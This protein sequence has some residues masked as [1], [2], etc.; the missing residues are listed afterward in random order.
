MTPSAIFGCS[1]NPEPNVGDVRQRIIERL[2]GRT[3]CVRADERG[4]AT[5]TS[6]DRRPMV[7]PDERADRDRGARGDTR[8]RQHPDRVDH[9]PPAGA[10]SAEGRRR[11][12]GADSSTIW[13]EA[14]SVAVI[15]LVLGSVLGAVNLYYLLEIVQ[16]DAV[17]MRLDYQYPIS[18]MLA[19]IPI[20]LAAAFVAALWP[21]EAAVRRSLVEAL[22]YE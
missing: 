2:R 4:G 22:A 1:S 12:A 15:G 9:R 10:W 11:P 13:L 21:S 3:A 14:A 8:H 17:G 19:L 18:T 7:R 6:S 5:A 20:M 16:R